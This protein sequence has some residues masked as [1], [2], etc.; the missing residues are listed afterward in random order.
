[1]SYATYSEAIE[2]I[3][4]EH[5]INFF[6]QVENLEPIGYGESARF[7]LIPNYE[8]EKIPTGSKKML[9]VV[10]NRLDNGCYEVISYV[11]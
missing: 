7:H 11:L 6:E 2:S 1:M 3:E 10:V 4:A 5:K 8:H 9:Q